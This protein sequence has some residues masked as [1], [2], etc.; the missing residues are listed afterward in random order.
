MTASHRRTG[1]AAVA[2]AFAATACSSA[3]GLGSILGGVLGQQGNQVSG[4]VQGL[5]TRN[6]QIGLQQSNGQTVALAYDNNTKVVYQDRVYNVTSLDP[7]DQVVARVQSSN[8]GGYYTDSVVVTQ[9]VN[10]STNTGSSSSSSSSSGVVQSLQGTVRAVDRNA[11]VFSL[12]AGTNV[13]L[14]VSLPYNANRNDVAKFQSLRSGDYV[15]LQGVYLNNS[16]VELR[17]FY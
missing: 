16:R 8:G 12:D 10:G 11:G 15:R 1:I 17:Q 3:G 6:Q 7:G 14:T 9:P 2:L 13:T 5:D 4:T